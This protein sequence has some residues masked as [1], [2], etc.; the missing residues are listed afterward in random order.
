[1]LKAVQVMLLFGSHLKRNLQALKFGVDACWF[2]AT[3]F[4]LLELP[5]QSL[6]VPTCGAECI[7]I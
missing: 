7:Q 5:A 1:M 2:D 4:G 6:S 3:R